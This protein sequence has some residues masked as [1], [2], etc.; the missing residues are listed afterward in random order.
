[1]SDESAWEQKRDEWAASEWLLRGKAHKRN[2]E[3][4]A[5]VL[6]PETGEYRTLDL[7]PRGDPCSFVTYRV[8]V[9]MLDPVEGPRGEDAPTLAEACE[10]IEALL[11]DDFAKTGDDPRALARAFLERAAPRGRR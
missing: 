6:D 8:R 3:V 4:F 9:E 10:V 7:T 1:M 5:R 11:L 2:V